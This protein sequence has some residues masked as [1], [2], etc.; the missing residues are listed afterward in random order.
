MRVFGIFEYRRVGEAD[1]LLGVV[2]AECWEIA[3]NKARAAGFDIDS[4][5]IGFREIDRVID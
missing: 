4:N 3:E 1:D 2:V 5:Q